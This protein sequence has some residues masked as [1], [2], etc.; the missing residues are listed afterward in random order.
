MDLAAGPLTKGFLKA[1][2]SSA[3]GFLKTAEN[4]LM[5]ICQQQRL[6]ETFL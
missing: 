1:V 6:S 2:S 4:C 3:K 5:V